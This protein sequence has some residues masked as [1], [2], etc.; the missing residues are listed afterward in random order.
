MYC[1]KNPKTNVAVVL[2][3]IETDDAVLPEPVFIGLDDFL[4]APRPS[5]VVWAIDP[6]HA[7]VARFAHVK[8]SHRGCSLHILLTAPAGRPYYFYTRINGSCLEYDTVWVNTNVAAWQQLIKSI[9]LDRPRTFAPGLGAPVW[10]DEP[11]LFFNGVPATLAFTPTHQCLPY[12]YG[13][14]CREL[15]ATDVLSLHDPQPFW[16]KGGAYPLN[17]LYRNPYAL[18][19]QV[20][21]PGAFKPLGLL[22][23]RVFSQLGPYFTPDKGWVVRDNVSLDFLASCLGQSQ[24]AF[25]PFKPGHLTFGQL[26]W[27]YGHRVDAEDVNAFARQAARWVT[28]Y[29]NFNLGPRLDYLV[30][31][32]PIHYLNRLQKNNVTQY[33]LTPEADQQQ[34]KM[35]L[36]GQQYGLRWV[37]TPPLDLLYAY[38]AQ[39][40]PVHW[41]VSEPNPAAIAMPHGREDHEHVFHVE[42][43]RF[44]WSRRHQPGVPLTAGA[45]KLEYLRRAGANVDPRLFE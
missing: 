5:N 38:F 6:S 15:T 26:E 31:Q 12:V 32:D 34:Q 7:K 4:A 45:L 40:V 16:V 25:I 39:F 22:K 29:R 3:G 28:A 20:V 24:F 2:P 1:F 27:F 18:N 17:W 30:T 35:R 8:P 21:Q 33:G 44:L 9:Y 42:L 43:K 14:H 13:H 11:T 36:L 23:Q 37:V 19:S 41:Y 10:R